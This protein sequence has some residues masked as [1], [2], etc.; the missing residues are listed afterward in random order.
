[1]RFIVEESVFYGVY[2][3]ARNNLSL[4]A[5][6][7][8]CVIAPIHIPYCYKAIQIV[9]FVTKNYINCK[10]CI[11]LIHFLHNNKRTTDGKPFINWACTSFQPEEHLKWQFPTL[12]VLM[13]VARWNGKMM[14]KNFPLPVMARNLEMMVRC[15]KIQLQHR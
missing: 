10:K 9:Y 7:A 14:Q 8:D 11:K 5:L 4:H 3:L 15:K 12:L 1:M 2:I 13:R 6:H